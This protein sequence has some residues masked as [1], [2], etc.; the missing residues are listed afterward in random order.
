MPDLEFAGLV[1]WR[2]PGIVHKTEIETSIQH[3][4]MVAAATTSSAILSPWPLRPSARILANLT[5]KS[6]PPYKLFCHS[7]TSYQSLL[8]ALYLLCSSGLECFFTLVKFTCFS[9]PNSRPNTSL[10]INRSKL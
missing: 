2:V 8:P 9:K 5:N 1:T 4:T 7:H 3:Q 6:P 10:V